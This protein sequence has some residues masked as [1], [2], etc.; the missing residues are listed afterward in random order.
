MPQ[1]YKQYFDF[2]ET[3]GQTLFSPSNEQGIESLKNKINSEKRYEVSNLSSIFIL[4]LSQGKYLDMTPSVE[5]LT[6]YSSKYIINS[7]VNM[8]VEKYHPLDGNLYFQ[9]I[10]FRNIDFLRQRP[11]E[12]SNFR[13]TYNY[14]FKTKRG[15]YIM[16]FQEM[17]VLRSA[18]DGTPTVV[19]IS[20][21]DISHFASGTKII[22]RIDDMR[23]GEQVHKHIHF[24]TEE[25]SVL[26]RKEI[27]VL[28]W[29]VEG[30]SCDAIARKLQL[31]IYT[32]YNHRKNILEKTNCD[33]IADVLKYA[34]ERQI[35]K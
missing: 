23:S 9:D 12:S 18:P 16:L 5:S 35:L 20:L 24:L 21:T 27:E 1:I 25:A 8:I 2:I 30:L 17:I 10:F 29:V 13:F 19:L 33:N 34:V 31:S 11:Q 7:G 6:G 3:S 15:E 28:K 14:R 22:H 26:S 4:D 32:V